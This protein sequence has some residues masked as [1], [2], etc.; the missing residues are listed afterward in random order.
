MVSISKE[1]GDIGVNGKVVVV[2]GTDIIVEGLAHQ[3]LNGSKV[4][5]VGNQS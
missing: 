3:Y 4:G 1:R 5:Q 2:S